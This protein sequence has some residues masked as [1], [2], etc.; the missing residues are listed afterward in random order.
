MVPGHEIAG[1]AVGSEVTEYQVGD[2]VGVGFLVNSCGACESCRAGTEQFGTKGSVQTYNDTDFDGSRTY[3]GYSRQIVVRESF[4]FQL[5][6]GIDVN[7]AAPLLCAG[8]TTYSPLPRWGASR[9]KSVAVVG[10]GGLGHMGGKIAVALSAEVTVLSQGLKKQ[11]DGLRLGAANYYSTED[12]S[13]FDALRGRFDII[14]NTVSA[15]LPSDAYLSMLRVHRGY[16]RDS[17]NA[18]ILRPTP[19]R[20]RD[21]AHRRRRDQHGLRAHRASRRAM[22][23]RH[24]RQHH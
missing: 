2:P 7:A 9:G 8:I 5:P 23:V 22:S 10:L 20:R 14:L 12:D 16:I 1:T 6:E 13:T 18:G 3:G 24:Q 15:T 21:R 11:Q 4:V 17:G 19:D